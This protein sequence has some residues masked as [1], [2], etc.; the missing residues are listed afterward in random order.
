MTAEIGRKGVSSVIQMF[1]EPGYDAQMNPSPPWEIL[2][3]PP[4]KGELSSET[5]ALSP[6]AQAEG[7]LPMF[8]SDILL[9]KKRS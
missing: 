1:H 6:L 3:I 8:A 2:D 7:L 4:R 5:T 9:F